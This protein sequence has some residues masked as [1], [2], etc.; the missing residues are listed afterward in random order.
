MKICKMEKVVYKIIQHYFLFIM[1]REL[2]FFQQGLFNIKYF[3]KREMV[4]IIIF[5]TAIRNK[6]VL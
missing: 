6:N 4:R 3:R 2:N 5:K 1:K